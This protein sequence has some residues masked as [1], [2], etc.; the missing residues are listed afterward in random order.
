MIKFVYFDLGGVIINDLMN[1]GWS[2]LIRDLGVPKHSETEFNRTFEEFEALAL[3]GSRDID[4]AI[5]VIEEQTGFIFPEGYSFF[6]DIISRFTKNKSIW[7]IL[8]VTKSR[9]PIG[10]LTNAY[11]RM[12]QEVASRGLM[13]KIEWDTIVDSSEVGM[14]KPDQDIYEYSTK[15]ADVNPDE[16]LFIDNSK[17]NIDGA[18]RYGWQTFLYSPDIKNYSNSNLLDLI[19]L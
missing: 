1:G 4:L 6:E 19:N 7:P 8:K 11:L 18:N 13:P 17:K 16:I 14:K 3:V 10:L 15:L 2:E 12:R 9:Y 5:P